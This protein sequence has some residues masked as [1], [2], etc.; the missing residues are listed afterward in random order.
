MKRIITSVLTSFILF[1]ASTPLWSSQD[2][3]MS[4]VSQQPAAKSVKKGGEKLTASG[5]GD[6]GNTLEAPALP[7]GGLLDDFN[8]ADGPLGPDWAD[9]EG[10]A[11]IVNNAARG[12]G[13]GATT[14]VGGPVTDVLEADI[15][16]EIDASGY[17]AL[18]LNY[19]DND[20]NLYL[21][22]QQQD[23]GG[24]FDHAACYYGNNGSSFGLG[25][26]DL[27]QPFATAHMRVERVGTTVTITFSNIDG[28]GGMQQYVCTDTPLTGGTG[29][30]IGGWQNNASLDNFTAGAARESK[31]VPTTTAIGAI[32]LLLLVSTTGYFY[33]V[34]RS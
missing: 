29:I 14:F 34:R 2:I 12:T 11:S 32:L 15:D 18:V 33:L 19:A 28:G 24:T 16:A 6:P 31:V 30:G 1:M 7:G 9:Q 4:K 25:F 21:K 5:S 8:R 27:T 23:G 10:T 20:N 13:L 26:F 22:V 17:V 3:D